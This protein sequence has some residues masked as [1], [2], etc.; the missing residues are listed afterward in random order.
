MFPFS[1]IALSA[2][3]AMVISFALLLVWHRRSPMS[4]TWY[5][6]VPALMVGLSVLIWR[7]VGN[8]A[9]LNDDLIP[10]FSPND[11]LCPV[12]TYTFLGCYGAF[13]SPPDVQRW[14]RI[15]AAL[16]IVSLIVN[17]VTI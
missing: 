16:T 10:G 17:V 13:R 9:Q 1:Q 4:L 11:L 8:L 15:R 3:V 6:F 14:E 2:A 7:S 5:V 12:I